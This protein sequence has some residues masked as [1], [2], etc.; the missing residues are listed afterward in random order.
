MVQD[1]FTRNAI[2]QLCI[3][4][5]RQTKS[6][7]FSTKPFYW[8]VEFEHPQKIVLLPVVP[9]FSHRATSRCSRIHRHYSSTWSSFPKKALPTAFYINHK[10]HVTGAGTNMKNTHTS[11][12]V[13]TSLPF[14]QTIPVLGCIFEK[15]LKVKPSK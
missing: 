2:S 13:V 3:P 9:I 11:A 10:H 5:N 7:L 14:S 12:S 1:L 15:S 4:E 8:H 6:T